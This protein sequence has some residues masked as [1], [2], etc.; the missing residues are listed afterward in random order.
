MGFAKGKRTAVICGAGAAA[1]LLLGLL[2]LPEIEIRHHLEKLR[3]EPAHLDELVRYPVGHRTWEAVRR[4]AGTS[5]GRDAI[6]RHYLKAILQEQSHLKNYYRTIRG[7]GDRAFLLFWMTRESRFQEYYCPNGPG[8]GAT[9]GSQK[10]ET[11]WRILSIQDLLV[12]AEDEPF[13]FE[14]EPGLAFRIVGKDRIRKEIA[15]LVPA[16]EYACLVM[17]AGVPDE[18]IL[19]PTP[20]PVDTKSQPDPVETERELSK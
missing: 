7:S 3:R 1:V 20:V 2:S 11:P 4:Y 17:K 10:V 9:Y 13:T 18:G 15:D 6:R 16:L 19:M 5:R 8:T 12:G 14:D